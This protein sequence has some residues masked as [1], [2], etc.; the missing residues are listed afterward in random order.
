[1]EVSQSEYAT[2]CC[3]DES[4]I[5]PFSTNTYSMDHGELS[6]RHMSTLGC[7]PVTGIYLKQRDNDSNKHMSIGTGVTLIPGLDLVRY[8]RRIDMEEKSISKL[9]GIISI[10]IKKSNKW[11]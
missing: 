3:G 10:V 6:M 9:G 11:R 4:L 5:D 1:M 8:W 7:L 2:Y